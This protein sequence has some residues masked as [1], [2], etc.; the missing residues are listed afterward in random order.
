MTYKLTK[1]NTAGLLFALLLIRLVLPV[2]AE[3]NDPT[4]TNPPLLEA[5]QPDGQ[6]LTD[7]QQITYEKSVIMINSVRQDYDYTTPWKKSPMSSSLGTGFVIE[8]GRILTNAHNVSNVRYIEVKKQNLAQRYPARIEYIGHDCDLAILTVDDPGFYDDT[9]PLDFGPLPKV[10]ST[11]ITCGFPVGGRQVSI[12]E[13]VVSRVEISN[14]SHTQADV[15]IVVQTDAA[16]N[17]G[18]SGGPVL[19]DGKV[20][21]VAFQGLQ[22]AE[23]IG[24]M[25]P[26]TVIKHFLTDITD[27]T[28]DGFGSMGITTFEGL[29]SPA[30]HKYLS[31]PEDAEG[32]I[33]LWVQPNSSAEKVLMPGDVLTKI[34]DFDIDND[35]MIRIYG[36]SLEMSEAV[37]RKQ[38]GQD[39]SLQLYRDGQLVNST[40][41]ISPNIPVLSWARQYDYQPKYLVYA[42][43]TFVP[44]NRNYLETFGRNWPSDMPFYLRYL[45][46]NW[47]QIDTDK[48]RTEYVVLSEI[49]PDQINTYCGAYRGQV[50]KKV[51]GT[52]IYSLQDV[53]EALKKPDGQ[54]C[55]VEF[56]DQPAP[57]ILEA[58][59]TAQRQQT[60]LEQYEVPSPTN[61]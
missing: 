19:Q 23:N 60:I 38:I 46:Y 53:R 34:D 13:G 14:Y 9:K 57:L 24:Y 27:G 45:F 49:L 29:H 40:V 25:I 44:V 50:V 20:V 16:I 33:V 32:V 61:M 4:S 17:P 39:I 26:T 22:A 58:E 10:N 7:G 54:F 37:E 12:T 43:L 30:Y 21:G 51:N 11:V 52:M 1:Q 15:H 8:G 6:D 5:A 18:N 3:P 31:L 55:R 48:Q 41:K 2:C 42:G 47:G 28:Y 59:E 35:G 56:F 36:L